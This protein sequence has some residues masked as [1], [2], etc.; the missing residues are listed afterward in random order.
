MNID[1]RSQSAHV[2]LS[3]G[4]NFICEKVYYSLVYN[5]THF[6]GYRVSVFVSNRLERFYDAGTDLPTME[7]ARGLLESFLKNAN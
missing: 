4:F 1:Y 2:T 3:I 7:G 6:D 5:T